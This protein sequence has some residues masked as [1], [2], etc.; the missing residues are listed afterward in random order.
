[1]F[2]G[3]LFDLLDEGIFEF[4]SLLAVKI[5][6]VLCLDG[7]AAVLQTFLAVH[8]EAGIHF[9]GSRSAFDRRSSAVSIESDL[10][11]F[12]Q[13]EIS[14]LLQEDDA[15]THMRIDLFQ[16]FLFVFFQFHDFLR[17]FY[18]SIVTYKT[19]VFMM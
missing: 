16:M 12:L 1:M 17:V 4:L 3:R 9:S 8:K 18:T 5:Q 10:S 19:S 6:P 2:A 13:R 11:G 7:K 14:V 15:F